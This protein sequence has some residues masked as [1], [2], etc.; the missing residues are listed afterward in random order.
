MEITLG[1]FFHTIKWARI[2]QAP[3]RRFTIPR[4]LSFLVRL[5]VVRCLEIWFQFSVSIECAEFK[6]FFVLVVGKN[7]AFVARCS[8]CGR[9]YTHQRSLMRHVRYECIAVAPRFQCTKCGM[10]FRR[11]MFLNKHHENCPWTSGAVRWR[12]SNSANISLS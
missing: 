9:V 3:L 1:D 6:S 8:D 11:R 7:G 12:F 5:T 4:Q 10:Q 2:V